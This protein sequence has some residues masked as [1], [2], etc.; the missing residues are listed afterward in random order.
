MLDSPSSNAPAAHWLWIGRVLSAFVVLF[1]LFS[2]VIKLI[3]RPEVVQTFT[4]LG[5]PTKFAL[6]VGLIE[7]T[8][9]VLYAIPR[10]AVLG[11]VL[12]TALLG[13]A[14]AA[15][16]R[17]ESPLFSHTLFGVYVGVIAWVALLLRE[18]RLWRL[19]PLRSS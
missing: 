3:G 4:E 13:G 18:P 6:T 11:A 10:T 2:S 12:L 1:L 16:L 9:I 7:L 17:A 5:Y 14:I 8:C 19:F 15:R